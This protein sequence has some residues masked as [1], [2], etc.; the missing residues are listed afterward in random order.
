MKD[1]VSIGNEVSQNLVIADATPL[2]AKTAV[3]LNGV[4]I[5][6]SSCR[7]IVEYTYLIA[8]VEQPFCEM[9]PDKSGSAGYQSTH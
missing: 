2:K 1:Y 3:M 8:Q 4:E 9:G 5:I 7:K 6:E